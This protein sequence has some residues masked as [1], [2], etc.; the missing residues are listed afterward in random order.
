M[1]FDLVIFGAYSF[2]ECTVFL[3]NLTGCLG[4]VIHRSV[5]LFAP[6]PC[7]PINFYPYH[8][9]LKIIINKLIKARRATLKWA[10]NGLLGV[11]TRL[12]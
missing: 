9:L 10:P 8:S 11:V 5:V 12:L 6:L 7:P 4:E 1:D 3:G 2:G